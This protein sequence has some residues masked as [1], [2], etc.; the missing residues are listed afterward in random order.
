MQVQGGAGHLLQLPGGEEVIKV[1]VG[2]DDAHH[3]QAMGVQAG[4]DLLRVATRVDDEGL[5]ADR[6]ADD[7]AVA[8]QRADG[9]GFADQGGFC[10]VHRSNPVEQMTECRTG[11]LCLRRRSSLH[12][13]KSLATLHGR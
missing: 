7:G 12:F 4:E 6:V 13:K 2:M 10:R 3:F 5:F 1:R 11:R 8:L 9:E